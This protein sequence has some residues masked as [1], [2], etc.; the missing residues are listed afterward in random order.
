MGDLIPSFPTNIYEPTGSQPHQLGRILE[1]VA[2]GRKSRRLACT[3][4]ACA[5]KDVQPS[6]PKPYLNPGTTHIL[7]P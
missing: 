6:T 4:S 5:S 7:N 2:S 1:E 3:G